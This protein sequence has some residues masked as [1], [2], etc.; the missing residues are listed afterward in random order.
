MR[1]IPT[2]D[3]LDV[4]S[5][6]D[7]VS[8]GHQ[9]QFVA[10]MAQWGLPLDRKFRVNG[11]DYT[12]KDFINHS[13]MRAR[14]TANQELGWTIL[15]LAQFFGTDLQWTNRAGENLKFEDLI[16]Y[17]LD[18]PMDTAA[19]GGTH[20]LFGLTWSYYLHLRNGGKTVGVWKDVA[21]TLE[22]HKNLARQYQNSDGS[23]STNFFRE[24]GDAKDAALRMNTTGHTL[25]WLALA[26]NDAELR[27]PWVENAVNSLALMFFNVRNQEM[28]GGALYHATHGLILY[29]ARVFDSSSQGF[30]GANFPHYVLPPKESTASSR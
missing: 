5:L 23:F 28:D 29:Y 16:R 2:Q 20:R 30:L 27:Q 4:E 21:D 22:K 15:I 19:C 12:F 24:R 13:K 17:E 6:M 7:F 9:D 25:E 8:Q 26:M 11:K 10:E 1:F 18:Q 3:G 14:T